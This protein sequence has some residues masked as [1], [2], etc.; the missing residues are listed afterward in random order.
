[1]SFSFR[2]RYCDTFPLVTDGRQQVATVDAFTLDYPAMTAIREEI[3]TIV[4][5]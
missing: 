1:L 4:I 3:A 5:V 2:R